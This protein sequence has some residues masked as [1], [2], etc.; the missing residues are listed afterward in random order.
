[1]QQEPGQ[2]DPPGRPVERPVEHELRSDDLLGLAV[3]DG[4]G[5]CF[6]EPFQLVDL[7]VGNP[8]GGGRGELLGDRGLQPE[9]V[10]DVAASQRH[11]HM[12]A[13]RLELHHALSA[14]RA[15]RLA[16]GGDAD[17]QL[18]GRLVEPDERAGPQRPGHDVGPQTGGH[19]VGQLLAAHRPP[20][21][22]PGSGGCVH[23][24]SPVLRPLL[25][26]GCPRAAEAI[27]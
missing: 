14:Q 2:L 9:D 21:L 11:H 5:E 10:L 15:Q 22:R 23:W 8:L 18:R 13:M 16:H 17:P 7:R 19:L 27:V 3:P 1:M 26:W 20:R 25:A 24:A 6:V 12:P 4:R